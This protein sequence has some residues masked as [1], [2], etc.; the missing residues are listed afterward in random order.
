M[1]RDWHSTPRMLA[2]VLVV[3]PE[4]NARRALEELLAEEG[5][6]VATSAEMEDAL[7]WAQAF[8]PQVALIDE[9]AA[10]EPLLRGLRALDCV[11]IGMSART[12]SR[13][14]RGL[15]LDKPLKLGDL[16]RAVAV[17]AQKKEL[18]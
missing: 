6:E 1:A 14:Q 11:I 9:P 5:Y 2:R 8:R 10:T 17:A 7:R 18:P 3:D 4:V 16:F 12:P 13:G 15:V